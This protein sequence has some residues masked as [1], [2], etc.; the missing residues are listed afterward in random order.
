MLD[1]IL[2]D[3]EARAK[4][5]VEGDSAEFQLVKHFPKQLVPFGCHILVQM[6]V[7]RNFTPVDCGVPKVR[8]LML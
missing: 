4:R 5:N 7:L 8:N 2:L 3:S 6:L 1:L